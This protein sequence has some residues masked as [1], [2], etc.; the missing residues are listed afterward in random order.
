MRT[1]YSNS[2]TSA[3]TPSNNPIVLLHGWGMN[4]RIWQPCIRSL[5]EQVSSRVINVDLPGYGDN[6]DYSAGYQLNELAHW[7]EQ[8][9]QGHLQV[10][11][12]GW[13]LG[14]LVAQ[15]FAACYPE[16]TAR[17]SLVGSTPKFIADENWY[18]IDAK[19]LAMFA[20]QLERDHQLIISRFLAIQAMGSTSAKQDIKQ[21]KDLVTSAP[22]PQL[23]ALRQGL[24]LLLQE[25]LRQTW[26][27]LACPVDALFGKLDSLV[28]AKA[29]T[30]IQQ[31]NPKANITIVEKASHAP[32]ISHPEQFRDWI[33]TCVN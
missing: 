14:G 17:L 32:F 28:P 26:A 16:K 1:Q 6:N 23:Q 25:D 13:S 7:L 3:Q 33:L 30:D 2:Q 20:G 12:I 21:I 8:Q 5:P 27:N 10:H 15:Q 31:L 24:T 22:E 9:L 18:G 4:K 11:L 29:I 19:V